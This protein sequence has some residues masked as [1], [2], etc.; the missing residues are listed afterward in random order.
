MKFRNAEGS[1]VVEFLIFVVLGQLLVFSGGMHASQWMDKK[2]R[3][4][5]FANQLAR[6]HSLGKGD[7]LILAL[8]DDYGFGNVS[9]TYDSCS[10]PL[11]CITAQIEDLKAYGVSYNDAK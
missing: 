8:K 1:A 5:L 2:L 6:A 7:E 4:E 11:F 9:V 3:L 10:K